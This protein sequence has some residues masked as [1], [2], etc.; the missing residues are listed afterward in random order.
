MDAHELRRR[1]PE[2]FETP[3]VRLEKIHE[4]HAV[5]LR[6]SVLR[7]RAD[8][9]YVDWSRGDWELAQAR[10]FCRGSRQTMELDGRFLTYLVFERV[11][12]AANVKLTRRGPY[13]GL[14]D[15]HEFDWAVPACQIGYVGDSAQRGRGLMR[16]AA[17]AL[18]EQAFAWGLHRV[19]AWCDARNER[20]I[21]FA[22]GIGLRIEG[23]L[24]QAARDAEGALCDQMVL[25]RLSG[26][27]A[28]DAPSA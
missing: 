6:E 17:L 9:Q 20:S 1:S 4:S 23:R 3:R 11:P 10:R 22:Q 21:R 8:L 14:L 16:E 13:V 18:I 19:E 5:V 26:D 15:L 27:A 25:A 7:S 12:R 2:G 28:G 24:R